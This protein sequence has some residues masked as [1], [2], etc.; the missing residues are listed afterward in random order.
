MNY[1]LTIAASDNCGGAG[2]QQDC[3]V[4]H[5]LGYWALSGITSQNLKEVFAVEPVNPDLLQA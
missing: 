4:A 1:F 2:M 5:D 3:K